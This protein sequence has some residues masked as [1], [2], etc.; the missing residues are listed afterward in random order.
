MARINTDRVSD[1]L[2]YDRDIKGKRLIKLSAGVCAGKNK[3]F[4]KMVKE[5]P[6]LRVLFI[7]SRKNVVLAQ[8]E[9]MGAISFKDFDKLIEEEECLAEINGEGIKVICT[10][11]SIEKFLKYKYNRNDERTYLWDKFDLVIL[12]EAHALTT[13]AVFTENFYTERFIKHTYY[14]NPNCDIVFMSGTLEPLKWMIEAKNTPAMHELNYFDKCVHLEPDFVY[15]ASKE[16]VPQYLYNLWKAEEKVVYFANF[17]KNIGELT[18]YLLE[19]GVPAEALGYSFNYKEDDKKYF[20]KE[21]ANTLKNRI[22]DMDKSLTTD[23]IVP[24]NVKILFTTSK[25]KEGINIKNDDIK[26]TIAESHNKSE[27]IQMS[28]RVRGNNI[29]GQGIKRLII[30][31]DARQHRENKPNKFLYIYNKHIADGLTDTLKECVPIKKY[32][33]L[34]PYDLMKKLPQYD[35]EGNPKEPF[36]YIRYDYI[37]ENFVA[38]E[39]K[40]EGELQH[41]NDLDEFEEIANNSVCRRDG[42]GDFRLFSGEEVLKCEWFKWSECC[43]LP[44]IIAKEK[45]RIREDVKILAKEQFIEFLKK[46]KF[47]GEEA[48]ISYDDKEIIIRAEIIRLAEIYGYDELGIKKNFK[49]VGDMIKIF[50]FKFCEKG[51]FK[52]MKKDYRTYEI[53]KLSD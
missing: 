1:Y 25:N 33:I 20:S 3:A 31:G 10:N 34:E 37:G 36:K 32:K 38:Y 4:I 29:N 23:E 21:I 6:E 35:A 13:D 44:K 14:K 9:D 26:T 12:D 40:Y 28:G 53:V 27:L 42:S 19:H 52:G 46:N 24:D 48:H 45:D 18:N 5:H 7:T 51:K 8:I 30:V 11:A 39:G 41:K 50:G 22:A 15:V 16:R 43:V 49:R 47:I 2:N 17:I